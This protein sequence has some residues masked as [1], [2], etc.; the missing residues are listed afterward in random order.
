MVTLNL[1]KDDCK[2]AAELIEIYLPQ[3]CHDFYEA[4]EFDNIDWMRSMIAA[5]DELKKAASGGDKNSKT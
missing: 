5:M 2:N 4:G 1:D 3:A